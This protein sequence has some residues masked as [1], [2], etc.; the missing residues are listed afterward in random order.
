MLRLVST[1]IS[2]GAKFAN[3]RLMEELFAFL[4]EMETVMLMTTASPA[5]IIASVAQIQP[6]VSNASQDTP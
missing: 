3:R 4:V 6:L 5:L 2:K 1:A